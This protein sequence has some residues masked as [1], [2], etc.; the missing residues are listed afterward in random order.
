MTRL[1]SR[2]LVSPEDAVPMGLAPAA[3]DIYLCTRAPAPAASKP[4]A[5]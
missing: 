3:D 1:L 4:F 5:V 2:D